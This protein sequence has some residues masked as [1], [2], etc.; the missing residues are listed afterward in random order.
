MEVEKDD[1]EDKRL[2]GGVSAAS[3]PSETP[4]LHAEPHMG[5]QRGLLMAT[6]N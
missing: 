4:A 2:T 6:E 3:L 5:A 1:A